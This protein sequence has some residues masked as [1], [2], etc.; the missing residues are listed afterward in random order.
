MSN[1]DILDDLFGKIHKKNLEHEKVV[2]A[3]NK[4]DVRAEVIHDIKMPITYLQKQK[5][6]LDAVEKL[7]FK[8][9]LYSGAFG[10]GKTKWECHVVIRQCMMHP[11]AS[12]LMGCQTYTMINDTIIKTFLQEI[13]DIQGAID[14]AKLDFA[15]CKQYKIGE[16]KFIFFN[17]S[18]VIFR[19]LDDASKYKSLNLSGFS[20]DEP[21][22]IDESVFNMLS[23]RL[24]STATPTRHCVMGGNPS[25]KS[26]WVYVKFFEE[27]KN[28]P[29]CSNAECRSK[30]TVLHKKY[31]NY[32][33]YKCLKCNN[34][35][36]SEYYVV[37]TTSYDNVYLP[38]DYI[39]SMENAYDRDYLLRYLFGKWGSFEGLI[40]KDFSRDKHVTEVSKDVER[41]TERWGAYDHGYND[42]AVFLVLGSD[43]LKNLY[44]IDGFYIKEKTAHELAMMVKTYYT[45]Y[46]LSRLY[47]D[48][49][50]SG[51]IQEFVNFGMRALLGNN[52]I[53]SGIVKLKSYFK[54]G[55]IFIANDLADEKGNNF[56][57]NELESYR[58]DSRK[59]YSEKPVDK[60]NHSLDALRY[61]VTDFNAFEKRASAITGFFNRRNWI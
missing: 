48:P 24:R 3:L 31:D 8:N 12:W 11:R 27:H 29:R 10:A 30:K 14:K 56:M 21:P 33:V 4:L 39:P 32:N 9:V 45:K 25:S 19:Q 57:I 49:S 18:E 55:S 54:T 58:Y 5:Q 59:K 23:G 35:F 52:D 26:S 13:D 40:Y 15:L 34:V 41:Y 60:D 17:D 44:V 16:H 53:N 46:Q 36:N 1:D 2:E 43:K 7:G 22:D 42:P 50:A 47:S 28:P 37:E 6:A 38:S 20:I 61:G 51:A